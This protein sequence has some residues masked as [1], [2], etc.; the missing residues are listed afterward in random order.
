MP[1]SVERRFTRAGESPYASVAFRLA[2]SEIRNPNG[3]VVFKLDGLEV[4]AAWSQVAVDI[5]AQKY[6]RK[7]GVPAR[8]KAVHEKGVPG[9]AVAPRRRRGRARRAAGGRA[10]RR[11]DQRAA[12]VRPAGRHLDLLGLEGRLLR[13]RGGRAR[14]LRRDA[15]HAGAARWRRRTRR[16]GSTPACTGPTASTGRRRATS[17]STRRPARCRASTSAYERPQPHACFIQSISDDLVNEGG[18]MDLWVR[19][20][21]LFKYGSGTG[22]NFSALRGENEPLSGGGK[23]SG[24]DE[25]PQDR[26]PRRRRHQ[27]RRH[28]AARRQDGDLSTSTT[29]T[30]RSSSTGRW[31]RSRRW[32]RWSPARALL[33]RHAGAIMA[34]CHDAA[35][36]GDGPVRSRARTRRCARRCARR[37]KAI[38]PEGAIQ[39]VILYASQ[40]YPSDRG[41]DLRRPTGTATPT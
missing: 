22:T 20:A 35:F 18:I 34:A 30:S 6:F 8:L 26:R 36:A 39:Q 2:S 12:G 19:E 32:P 38:L 4:P 24:P 31:S 25:L 7:A 23:S 29:R 28:H 3:S 11:R 10:L 41:P 14:L 9:V 17:T 13:R 40:G 1:I 15:L 16:S 5:L 37:R 27:V 33:Q 21:R